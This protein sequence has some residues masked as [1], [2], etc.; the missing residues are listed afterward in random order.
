M[1]ASERDQRYSS[2]L[3]LTSTLDGG[4]GGQ[5]HVPNV[6]SQ[7]KRPGTHFKRRWVGSRACLVVGAENL[8]PTRP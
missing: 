3:S 6:M 1:K 5:G 4:E 2:N 7:D 8:A